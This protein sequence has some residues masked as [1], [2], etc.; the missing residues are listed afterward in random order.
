MANFTVTISSV[1][2][3]PVATVGRVGV[4]GP[5]GLTWRGDW[6]GATAYLIR[7]AVFYGG[8]AWYAL[9]AG[10]NQ[11]PKTA[12]AYWTLLALGW[13]YRGNW[14]GATAYN[15]ADVV[16][17]GGG[18][19]YALQAGTN[20]NPKT[21][22]AYWG[23]VS[24]GGNWLGAW[25]SGTLYY[26]GDVISFH[27][28]TF[29]ALQAGTN[30]NPRT[31]A[32]YW[33]MVAD[34]FYWL[35]AWDSGTAYYKGD[36]VSYNGASYVALQAGTNKNPVT[37]TAYWGVLAA[38]GDDYPAAYKSGAGP[39]TPALGEAG[40]MLWVSH[41]AANVVSIPLNASVPF[42]V[43]TKISVIQEGAG[44]TTITAAAG[45]T[46][47]GVVA[48]SCLLWQQYSVVTLV[49]RAADTWVVFGARGAVA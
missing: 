44:A 32:A 13:N 5:V 20:Q 49:K 27:G 36:A 8:S 31:E 1:T 12:P 43:G 21:Q 19:Y 35:A 23:L 9:Q 2:G 30:K 15:L 47:N 16:Y 18:T 33:G 17:C 10:T 48:G 41:T 24:A 37:E 25:D 38:R 29:F 34:G 7:D 6:S 45:V 22:T 28:A 39:H 3:S 14:S 40:Y 46:L 4:Q 11:N 26:A 42:P